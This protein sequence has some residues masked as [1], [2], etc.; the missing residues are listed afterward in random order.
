MPDTMKIY[1]H[2]GNQETPY[3]AIC[4]YTYDTRRVERWTYILLD[5]DKKPVTEE[6][7]KS[8]NGKRTELEALDAVN[9]T[10][11]TEVR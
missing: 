1:S 4:G 11:Y 7:E 2:N 10:E 6:S 9:G 5:K 3:F 8:D